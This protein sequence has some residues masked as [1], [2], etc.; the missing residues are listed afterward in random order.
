M[1]ICMLC[2]ARYFQADH[3]ASVRLVLPRETI[4]LFPQEPT[5]PGPPHVYLRLNL[6]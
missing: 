4:S 3:G 2:K 1:K 6:P 5:H